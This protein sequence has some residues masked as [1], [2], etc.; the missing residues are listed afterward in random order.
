MLYLLYGE[1]YQIKK[2]VD[3]II[4]DNNILDINISKYDL[5]AYNYKDVL[6]DCT[7]ISLF[8]D[9]KA[10]IVSNA[11][12]FTS[13]K[14][15]ID[16]EKFEEYIPNYNPNAIVIFTLED[17][18]DE[19]KKTVKLIRKHGVVKEFNTSD[20][21]NDIVKSMLD[22]Y[23]MDLKTINRFIELV[24]ND[25]Y[26]ISNELDK[27]KLY[28]GEDKN[29]TIEDVNNVTTNNIDID[30]FKLMDAIM[31]NKKE[32]AIERYHNML[33]YNTEPIQIIIALANKYRLMYQVKTLFKLGYTE[34]DM[35]KELKQ[36][37][38]YIFVLNKLSK[39][40]SASYLLNE[41]KELAK[42]DYDIKSGNM[43]DELALELYILKK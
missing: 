13:A 9:K 31:E 4:K 37:P 2:E 33:L 35:A 21:P 22:D 34:G 40:Y 28:K 10:I 29:I 15:G 32:D 26:N 39:S 14:T 7:S 23:Q 19:R 12:I 11:S 38:K 36:S 5:D 3:K 17:K 16:I 6:E 27:L 20:N 30:L 42:L 1:A 43:E 41:I 24:G 8:D 25:T 18:L